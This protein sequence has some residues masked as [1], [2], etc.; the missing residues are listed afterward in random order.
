[1]E[2]EKQMVGFHG[3]ILIDT[4]NDSSSD[5]QVLMGCGRT[6]N[7]CFVTTRTFPLAPRLVLKQ[8]SF[9]F[10]MRNNNLQPVFDLS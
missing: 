3:V 2:C 5:I 8:V 6:N 9:D 1:M 4:H 10:D 7:A